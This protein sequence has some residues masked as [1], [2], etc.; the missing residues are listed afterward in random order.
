MT[1]FAHFH[2]RLPALLSSLILAVAA[3]PAM[4]QIDQNSGASVV[5]AGSAPS[6]VIQDDQ[7]GAERQSGTL[8]QDQLAG[9]RPA[10]FGAE[11]FRDD[12]SASVEGVSDPNYVIQPGDIVSVTTYGLVNQTAQL[13]VDAEGNIALPN[14]GPV[15]IAGTRAADVD[16]VVGAAA[17]QVYQSTVQVYA[18]V[19][20]AGEIQVFVTG[21]VLRPGGHTG[22]SQ[23]SVIGFCRMRGY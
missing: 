3:I 23:A 2:I 7:R 18:T 10:P 6:A 16:G 5:G 1:R 8:R 15:Q 17:S 11:L 20:N 4:A 9:W 12:S 14:V 19:A 22:T 21:P 13:V